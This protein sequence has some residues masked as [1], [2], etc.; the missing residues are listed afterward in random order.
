VP[1][2]L[3]LVAVFLSGLLLSPKEAALSQAVYLLLGIIGLPVFSKFG[4]GW[5]VVAGPTGGYILS[6]PFMAFITAYVLQKT[7]Q[8]NIP[9]ILPG[10]LISLIFC[11]L[12]GSL[13][14]SM[15]TGWSFAR[16]LGAGAVPFIIFDLL[17]IAL[18]AV[19]APMLRRALSRR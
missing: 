4:G 19:T 10:M 3:S 14:L 6:Y 8:K 11:Y 7:H 18:C 13:W 9:A 16:A 2:S 12:L 5:G 17:K 15:V 1:I